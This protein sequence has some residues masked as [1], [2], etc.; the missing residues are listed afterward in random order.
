M[1]VSSTYFGIREKLATFTLLIQLFYNTI[2][3]F[4]EEDLF[5]RI[6]AILIYVVSR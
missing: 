6:R 5:F 4:V 2:D 1:D 3:S